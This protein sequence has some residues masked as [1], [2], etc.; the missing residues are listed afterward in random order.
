[1]HLSSSVRDLM[2]FLVIVMCCGAASTVNAQDA[3]YGKVSTDPSGNLHINSTAPASGTTV[4]LDGV[5]SAALDSRLQALEAPS[6]TALEWTYSWSA[7]SILTA[8]SA[9]TPFDSSGLLR[10]KNPSGATPANISGVQA[11]HLVGGTVD[12]PGGAIAK[13]NKAVFGKENPT[14]YSLAMEFAYFSLPTGGGSWTILFAGAGS[15]SLVLYATDAQASDSV[16]LFSLLR[17]NSPSCESQCSDAST[18]PPPAVSCDHSTG[19]RR[20]TILR[21]QAEFVNSV[22][23]TITGILDCSQ[24]PYTRTLETFQMDYWKSQGSFDN[25]PASVVF[26][27]SGGTSREFDIYSMRITVTNRSA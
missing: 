25:G 12:I 21:M 10:I 20:F 3:N 23:A 24:V 19:T 1:M 16:A 18:A 15:A 5:S 14:N 6:A 4:Y 17:G 7:A 11:V 26:G 13:Q 8:T 9:G 2:L 22:P 27:S